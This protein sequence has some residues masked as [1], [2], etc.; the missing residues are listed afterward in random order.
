[1]VVRRLNIPVDFG[2]AFL[3]IRWS[4]HVLVYPKVELAGSAA[5]GR[6]G[7]QRV[8]SPSG[9]GVVYGG[10]SGSAAAGTA[11]NSAGLAE[12][13]Q[14]APISGVSASTE[15]CWPATETREGRRHGKKIPRQRTESKHKS[16]FSKKM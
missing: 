5:R 14:I 12:S 11:K 8:D 4:D 9:E 16:C 7:G 10:D 6:S 1:M 2:L 3:R 13:W 15:S